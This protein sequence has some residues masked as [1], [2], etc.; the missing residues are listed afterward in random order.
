LTFIS[1]RR[2]ASGSSA[3]LRAK[4][5]KASSAGNSETDCRGRRQHPY[6]AT[7]FANLAAICYHQ[8]RY[9]EAESLHRRALAIRENALGSEHPYTAQSLNN[10]AVLYDEQGRYAEAEPLYRRAL[11]IREK[12]LGSEHPYTAT[13][14]RN[15]PE[16]LRKL[17]RRAEAKNLEV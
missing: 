5:C 7:S 12:A 3:R 16:L 4:S 13:T 6:T 14:V 15:Y 8:G 17:G 1:S 11:A 2:S 10:L 9:T